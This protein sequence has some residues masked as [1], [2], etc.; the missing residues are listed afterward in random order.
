M[1]AKALRIFPVSL[2]LG[3]LLSGCAAG[4]SQP[5]NN[6]VNPANPV[7]SISSLSPSAV[8][9]G[10]QSFSV[11]VNGSNFL[12]TSVVRWNA[13]ERFTTFVNNSQLTASILASDVAVASTENITVVNPA[14]GGGTSNSATF[15]VN[16]LVPVISA[17]GPSS[18]IAGAGAFTLS[19][20]GSG[21]LQGSVVRWNGSDRPTTF[22]S[23]T[24]LQAAI[25]ASDIAS[26]GLAQV[27]VYT[28]PPGG[29]VSTAATFTMIS[30]T[31]PVPVINAFFP[32]QL[33]SGGGNFVLQVWGY[34]FVQGSVVRW[35]GSDRPTTFADMV[36]V[37]AAI[38]ASDIASVGSA[39]VTVY[40]PPPGGGISNALNFNVVQEGVGVIERVSVD[41]NGA[42]FESA[43]SY[44]WFAG[45]SGDG[46]FVAFD[47][48]DPSYSMKVPQQVFVRDTCR[49]GPSGCAPSTVQVSVANDGSQGNNG[50]L[51]AAISADGR[52]VA[53]SS[54]SSNLVPDDS[55]GF[56][57]VMLRDT[58]AGAPAGCTP[59]TTRVSVATD[60]TQGDNGSAWPTISAN[61]RFVAFYS[62]ASNLVADD[63]NGTGDS[64]VRDTCFGAP[65]GCVPSTIR[66][67]VSNDGS[68]GIYGSGIPSVSANG[69][70]V[71]F[72]S[73]EVFVRDT[74]AGAPSGCT[75]STTLVSV[76]NDGSQGNDAAG[77]PVI[78]ANG[79]FVSFGSY[80]SNL[81]AGDTNG[82]GDIFVR[83]TCVGAPTG[84]TPSTTLV[85]V[86]IDGSQGNY[87]SW[88]WWA[89]ISGDGRFV[90]FNTWATNF[91]PWGSGNDQ[92][93]IF[94][95]D[96]C[97]GAPADC[98]PSTVRVNVGWDGSNSV[99][100]PYA[101]WREVAISADGRFVAFDSD[102]NNMV[103]DDTN[104][105]R[106]EV[107]CSD[108]FLARTGAVAI[109]TD[110]SMTPSAASVGIAHLSPLKADVGT[111]PSGWS[112]VEGATT[113]PRTPSFNYPRRRP[114]GRFPHE[115]MNT[116]E[117][118]P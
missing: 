109:P 104:R 70:F 49:G 47:N 16:N 23:A 106:D 43:D 11:T 42:Q 14:P 46:R 19:V 66:V 78:S 77:W 1:N 10:G 53:F 44:V 68:Q 28:P 108:V 98:T 67:S 116:K 99:N 4:Q 17:L 29:G 62:E 48:F 64:F 82:Y 63:T 13:S 12:S 25:S 52:F 75:P 89:P 59:S 86:G 32:S 72:E 73:G 45:I 33:F 5:I 6:P 80:S 74:C 103:P 24:Q 22:V 55:N 3:V 15:T 92:G 95:R 65:A 58:C 21:F 111:A 56:E 91:V 41:N 7:P 2:L 71:A 8:L 54:G 107:S 90:V 117:E 113:Q 40:T 112:M 115:S 38:S 34:G 20:S 76:A 27:T 83:D 18:A 26:V 39:Q 100:S 61:G 81:V 96:T 57:D 36:N 114:R 9:A 30:T 69:R 110:T 50:N 37:Q 87:D 79:R 97:V 101:G 60:G 84:C 31:L 102:A 93:D 85:S 35:N 51:D 118:K 88:I 105:C 94:V